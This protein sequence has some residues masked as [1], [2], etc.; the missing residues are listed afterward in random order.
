[1]YPTAVALP[2]GLHEVA[3]FFGLSRVQPL[4]EL[5]E[6]KQHLPADRDALAGAKCRHGVFQI[7]LLVERSAALVKAAQQ[8]QF[9]FLRSGLNIDRNHVFG[10][11]WQ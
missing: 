6:N 2:Q 5:V 9:S 7:Q 1:L 4:L 10:E 8:A 11:T 3:A